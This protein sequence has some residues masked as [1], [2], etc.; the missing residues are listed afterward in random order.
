MRAVFAALC[1]NNGAKDGRGG[2]AEL[3]EEHSE[4]A[5]NGAKKKPAMKMKLARE[6][7]DSF[8]LRRRDINAMLAAAA[9]YET[10]E[11]TLTERALVCAGAAEM[12]A[13]PQTPAAV[14]INE[15]VEI[16][17]L[18]GTDNGEKF[19]NAA[20]DGIARRLRESRGEKE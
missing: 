9:P 7:A 18:Y 12:L 2:L 5:D 17:K 11:I 13:R 1:N 15:F 3:P 14:V 16:A 10:D 4:N 6:I 19:V 8:H 20:L